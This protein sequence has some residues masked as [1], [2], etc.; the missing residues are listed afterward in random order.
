MWCSNFIQHIISFVYPGPTTRRVYWSD[1][2]FVTLSGNKN[3]GERFYLRDRKVRSTETWYNFLF[4]GVFFSTAPLK[5]IWNKIEFFFF[6]KFI[7][8]KHRPYAV[9]DSAYK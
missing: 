5:S 4:D 7:F 6:W 2:K 8:P 1:V 9:G 3:I